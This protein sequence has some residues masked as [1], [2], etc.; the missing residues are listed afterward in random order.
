MFIPLKVTLTLTVAPGFTLEG[1]AETD[2]LAANACMGKRLTTRQS[3]IKIR[4]PRFFA[5]FILRPFSSLNI[6]IT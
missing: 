2:A 6:S 5:W 4:R 1:L 3:I